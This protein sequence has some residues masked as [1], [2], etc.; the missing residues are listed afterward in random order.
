M[1]NKNPVIYIYHSPISN[2]RLEFRKQQYLNVLFKREIRKLNSECKHFN[3]EYYAKQN[4]TF[5]AN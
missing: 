1:S 2:E 3:L 5:T 4:I